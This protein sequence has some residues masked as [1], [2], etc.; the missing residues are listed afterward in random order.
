MN[1]AQ[2]LA[3]DLGDPSATRPYFDSE[4]YFYK[5]VRRLTPRHPICRMLRIYLDDGW[6]SQLG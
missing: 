5:M 4:D 1:F 3:L 2:R 6:L